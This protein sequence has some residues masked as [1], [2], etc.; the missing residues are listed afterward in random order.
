MYVVQGFGPA[1]QSV[2]L[3]PFVVKLCTWLRLAGLPYEHR[4][5]DVRRT[6]NRKLPALVFPDGR[7]LADSAAILR[8]LSAEHGDPLGD[9]RLSPAQQATQRALAALLENDLYFA[10]VWR[11]WVPEANWVRL[12]PEIRR[13]LAQAGVPGF[14]TGL[15]APRVRAG[16]KAQ[17]N[18]QGT[19][20]KSVAE[21][22]ASALS[23]W[24]ALA[25]FLGDQPCIFGA[26]PCSFDAT[27]YAFIHT[28]LSAPFDSPA[29]DWVQAQPALVA[30][31]QRLT[32]INAT[33]P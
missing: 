23:A 30:Y 31:H 15:V 11:R 14:L 24:Q 2:D 13:Y 33:Q 26:V 7:V 27:V 8:T 3:S 28:L 5:G 25:H 16:V 20:R 21:I 17:L 18:A 29:K 32:Q 19:G 4:V 1:W 6:P 9:A 12:E 10:S 22:D